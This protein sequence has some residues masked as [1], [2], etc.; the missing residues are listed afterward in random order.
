MLPT[1]SNVQGVDCSWVQGGA[2]GTRIL[3]CDSINA[4]MLLARG[5]RSAKPRLVI[6]RGLFRHLYLRHKSITFNEVSFMIKICPWASSLEKISKS[7]CQNVILNLIFPK[8]C[9]KFSLT[10]GIQV[11]SGTVRQEK[12]EPGPSGPQK[13]V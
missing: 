6:L 10:F 13:L 2:G 1:T 4:P 12:V 9:R 3:I 7:Y 8:K 11:M 5:I